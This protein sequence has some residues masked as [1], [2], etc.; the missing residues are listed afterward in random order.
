M[1]SLLSFGCVIV[2]VVG[3][4]SAPDTD[5][6][7]QRAV[8]GVEEISEPLSDLSEQCGLASKILTLT[9]ESGDVAVITR[10]MTGTILING[11]G[12]AGATIS[13]VQRIAV[14]ERAA[15]DQTVI[16]DYGSGLFGLGT[17]TG[18]GVTVDLG[19]ASSG[20]SL[21]VIGTIGADSFVF[22]AAGLAINSDASVDVTMAHVTE[23]T[24]SLDD[25]DD[26]FSAMGNVATGAALGTAIVI[27][28][29]KGNDTLRGGAGND[30]LNGGDG[31]D[32]FT[33]GDGVVDD[34][35]DA[36]N[37]GGGADTADYSL[38][39][40]AVAISNDDLPNDGVLGG[41]E[42]DNI[43]ADIHTLKGGLGNDTITGGDGVDILWG[44]A[45]S[46][47]FDEGD[48][49][50]GG[51]TFNGGA[52]LDTVSYASRPVAVFVIIDAL[53]N[54]GQL[55]E[56]D[57]VMVDVENVIG[58]AGNDTITGSTA[59][60]VLSGSDGDDTLDGGAGNDRFDEGDQANGHDTMIGGAGIDTVDY[61]GRSADL[62]VRMD[63]T[64]ASGEAAGAEGDRIGAVTAGVDDVENVIGGIGED[65]I[66]GNS[67]D[68]QLEGGPDTDMATDTIDGGGGDDV[69]DGIGGDDDLDCGAGD[70]DVNLDTSTSSADSCE[71]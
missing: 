68:N 36:Y 49:A 14:T 44:N 40:A 5:V 52:G 18:P 53:A 33:N 10:T 15:G 58:G 61:S 63:G 46:D 50:N 45:G 55:G 42:I 65:T 24:I 27:Y 20:D 57:K 47:T 25:G 48:H 22:G 1:R 37:G 11:F 30:T 60:N 26:V 38:R 66:T 64:P 13:N 16:L 17:T 2:C 54:D 43:A 31:N 28:G 29:G 71:L 39:A 32:I 9:L 41:S 8:E 35:D 12:C 70:A 3:C 51:D 6:D 4:R 21:K 23:L 56:L 19:N 7:D 62:T 59:D 67:S 34:G 69:L